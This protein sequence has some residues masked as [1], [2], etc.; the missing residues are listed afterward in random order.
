MG[1]S[2]LGRSFLDAKNMGT[3]ASRVLGF[4]TWIH[5]LHLLG[6]SLQAGQF[7]RTGREGWWKH[8]FKH[9]SWR[10]IFLW[11]GSCLFFF[12]C[13]FS[14]ELCWILHLLS[15]VEIGRNMVGSLLIARLKTTWPA[16]CA[17]CD[18][19]R[20]SVITM[21]W[22]QGYHRREDRGRLPVLLPRWWSRLGE[23]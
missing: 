17:C 23:L 3:E 19:H 21:L 18:H 15:Q 10:V 9:F 22:C 13:L 8:V 4:R 1:C 6:T 20:S 14:L 16:V 12:G 5:V 7:N 11:V 2:V